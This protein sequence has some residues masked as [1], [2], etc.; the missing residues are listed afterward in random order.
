[1]LSTFVKQVL[2]VGQAQGFTKTAMKV[3]KT[4][5]PIERMKL[6]GQTILEECLPPQILYPFKC[7]V[8]VTQIRIAA[9]TG[10]PWLMALAVGAARQIIEQF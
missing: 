7:T 5:S 6:A 9:S 1:M 8:L 10:N 3:Y 2:V 4:S